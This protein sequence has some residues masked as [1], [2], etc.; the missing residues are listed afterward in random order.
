MRLYDLPAELESLML[1]YETLM[2]E[3]AGEVTPEVETLETEI[4]DYLKA[5]A[6]KVEAAAMVIKNLEAD[7]VA[8]KDEAKRLANRAKSIEN[9][10]ARLKSLTLMAVKM[11]GKIKTPRFTIWAQTSKATVAYSISP[12]IMPD[13]FAAMYPQYSRMT[14]ELDKR[15][16]QESAKAGEVIPPEILA[17]EKPGNDFLQIR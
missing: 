8:A 14:I 9:N 16:V 4:A 3:T 10:V 5:G 11:I 6:D 17:E 7:E 1:R 12:D 15:A 2:A 13:V